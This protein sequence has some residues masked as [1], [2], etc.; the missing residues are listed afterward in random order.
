[1]GKIA[2]LINQMI[3]RSLTSSVIISP[4][5]SDYRV[6]EVLATDSPDFENEIE[7]LIKSQE[8]T[9][10]KT[11]DDERLIE[12]KTTKKI[13]ENGRK[14][15]DL[16]GGNI[17]DLK[18]LSTEQF[19]NIRSLAT[20]PFGFMTRTILTKLRT[21]AGV[22]FI[23]TI[24]IEVAKFLIEEMFKP[25]RMFD[26]RFREQIDKQVIQFLT[27]K[28]QAE[29]R[30][31]YK[32]LITTTIGG[33]RGDSLRGQIGGNF[34]SDPLESGFYDPSYVRWTPSATRDMRNS[35]PGGILNPRT[36]RKGFSGR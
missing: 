17:G 36:Q 16:L 15:D 9:V 29:L 35:G 5:F 11:N 10:K 30:A 6:A 28:E 4:R 14:L 22:L 7:Q 12:D 26:Q 13:Q 2:D 19:G 21:G 1:L 18:K 27:R 8:S 3:Q 20:N 25:G 23:V 33:L 34:Y 32:S 24:A 31:G